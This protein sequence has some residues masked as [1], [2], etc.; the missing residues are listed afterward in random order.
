MLHLQNNRLLSTE[1]GPIYEVTFEE[2]AALR[3]LLKDKVVDNEHTVE[4]A[5]D[6]EMIDLGVL[7]G[8]PV[9]YNRTLTAPGI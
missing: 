7:D 2:W 4:E 3:W 1:F 6:Q 5:H 9:F 8:V